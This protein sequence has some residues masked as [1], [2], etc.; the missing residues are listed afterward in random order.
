MSP[1][2]KPP[3]E[4]LDNEEARRYLRPQKRLA[5]RRGT[6]A[7][8]VLR[9]ILRLSLTLGLLTVL[10]A[11]LYQAYLYAHSAPRF[12]LESLEAVAIANIHYVP[13]RLVRECFQQDVGHSVFFIPLEARR[14]A[15]EELPWVWRASVQRILPN[16]LR[17]V[18]EERIPVAFLRQGSELML[19]DAEGVLLEKPAEAS[20]EFPVLS[21]F[22]PALT[23]TERQARVALYL[24]FLRALDQAEKN[25]SRDISEVDLADTNNLRAIVSEN[26]QAVLLHFGRG[27]Y[28]EK[29]EAY[30]QHRS[31]WQK[32]AEPVYA[33][34]LR[35][36]GQLVLN[37]DPT[38]P[39]RGQGGSQR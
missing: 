32:G 34:D 14:R 36:R 29:Y 11:I 13:T 25:Y 4:R 28:Q 20:F 19:I 3:L 37:P 21:G 15:L 9:L 26:G 16:R 35:Y 22:S 33:V 27:F 18:L 30:L 1:E 10:S 24:E 17:V 39:S 31:L 23:P 5:V 38:V 2:E 8:K 6:S 7:R 12:Q